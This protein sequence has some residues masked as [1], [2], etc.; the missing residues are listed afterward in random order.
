MSCLFD[1]LSK[2][3]NITSYELRQLICDYIEKNPSILG[4]V[5]INDIIQWENNTDISSYIKNM[6]KT[7]TWGSALELKCF[8][9]MFKVNVL[10]HYRGKQIEFKSSKNSTHYINIQYTGN[11]YSRI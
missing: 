6:R 3:T 5:P 10:V 1:S 11:H 4:D 9:D 8:C 2:N 7:N